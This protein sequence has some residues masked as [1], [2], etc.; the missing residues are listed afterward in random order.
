MYMEIVVVWNPPKTVS[1]YRIPH[2]GRGALVFG[3]AAS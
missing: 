1:P 3:D 2:D